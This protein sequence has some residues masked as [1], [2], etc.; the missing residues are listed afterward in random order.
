MVENS[1]KDQNNSPS[2]DVLSMLS[3]EEE[4]G[5][6]D[7]L[8][9]GGVTIERDRVLAALAQRLFG[10]SEQATIGRYR[11]LHRLGSGA[12]GVVYAAHDPKLERKVALK[13]LR[14]RL[15]GRSEEIEREARALARLRH[16]NVVTVYE[17]GF[18]Q[19]QPFLAMDY[20][21]GLTL[22][23][24]LKL[25]RS[26]RAVLDVL[27]EAGEGLAAAHAAGLV[28]RD[29]KPDNVLVENGHARV[30]DFG[31]SRVGAFDQTFDES[32]DGEV[33]SVG[34]TASTIGGT[35]AYMAPEAFLGQ[36]TAKSDQFSFCA[37]L[38]ESLYG[39]RPFAATNVF[40]HVAAI[41]DGRLASPLAKRRVPRWLRKIAIRGLAADPSARWPSMRALLDAIANMRH[42]VQRRLFAGATLAGVL[43]GGFGVASL[44]SPES[45]PCSI[46][47]NAMASVWTESK[48]DA[49]EAAFL[50]LGLPYARDS[51]RRADIALSDY[52]S[53]WNEAQ[54]DACLA[55]FVQ[56]ER[57]E[58]LF[59]AHMQCLTD[60][61]R[62]FEALVAAFEHPDLPLVG[63]AVTAAT[64]LPSVYE[65]DDLEALSRPQRPRAS[66]AM[67]ERFAQAQA[68]MR[69]GHYKQALADTQALAGE[70][71]PGDGVEL[72]A[73][74]RYLEAIL[75]DNLESTESAKAAARWAI[76]Y[77][78]ESADDRLRATAQLLLVT[79][80][81]ENLELDAARAWAML[82]ESTIARL[83]HPSPLQARLA[84]AR[85]DIAE[86]DGHYEEARAHF[87][88]AID[89]HLT[90]WDASDLRLASGY[91]RLSKALEGLSRFDEAL[92][93]AQKA[94]D[95]RMKGLGPFHPMMAKV[96]NAIGGT[97]ANMY[98][99]GEAVVHLQQAIVIASV[100][101]GPNHPVV[102]WA[103]ANMGNALAQGE[104]PL[105]SIPYYE[106]AI[107]IL[108]ASPTPTRG[109]LIDPMM[110]FG[111]VL[112]LTGQPRRA[113]DVLEQVL[114][115]QLETLGPDHA[116]LIY[117][118][119]NLAR[120]HCE[121]QEWELAV[122]D[123]RQAVAV[124]ESKLGGDHRLVGFARYSLGAALRG[125]GQL[126][127]AIAELKRAA[128][129]QR[130]A[131]LSPAE[132]GQTL[133]EL[134]HTYWDSGRREIAL[135]TARDARAFLSK[136][137]QTARELAEV[138]A[139][140]EQK[141]ATLGLSE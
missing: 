139:W 30:V 126:E 10:E 100:S 138:E 34:T 6:P 59:D 141:T 104:H 137:P 122:N 11:I 62:E 92:E 125:A 95:I 114:A 31:L 130:E 63:K 116:D 112:A 4:V 40:V 129:I 103:N 120:A 54:H 9:L 98:H 136:E 93:M 78:D 105:D 13:V 33:R 24:W 68:D 53:R 27:V 90:D 128:A 79:L 140:I 3:T 50:R 47:T 32:G 115:M 49:I 65:C 29:F 106:R 77:A 57:S 127:M 67:Y 94:M 119:T 48:R 42:R 43:I 7:P 71:D 101:L 108:K 118:Y 80:L 39:I 135:S 96:H 19:S 14:E 111:L 2:H 15:G 110:N 1:D 5:L 21:D 69:I 28:H 46:E 56:H 70:L 23:A 76:A 35:P 89:L 81:T 17:L 36:S 66:E 72:V 107:A 87:Q 41:Q 131:Q 12:R 86:V 113:I 123:A 58:A 20:V 82:V 75:L 121:V 88:A 55:T 117:V 85:G 84:T 37:A 44:S 60:L 26:W 18:H 51:W 38:Y 64:S 25:S 73:R 99:H 102:A 16:P 124:G 133:S 83:G 45:P 91:L 22:T 8:E 97:M 52:A 134:A 61:R 74:V 132:A 109:A